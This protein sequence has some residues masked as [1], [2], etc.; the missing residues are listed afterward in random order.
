MKWLHDIHWAGLQNWYLAPIFVVL[1]ILTL[2]NYHRLVQAAWQLMHPIY[3]KTLFSNFS[4]RRHGIK[5]GLVVGS[6]VAIFIA[7]LQPQWGIVEN[8]VTQEGR[9]LLIVLDISRSM[10]AQDF[11]PNRLE[12]AKL[13]I[14]NVLNKLKFERVGLVLFS[15]EAFLQCPLTAD[16]SSFLM[17]LEQVDVET[18]SS[19]STSLDRALMQAISVF[20]KVEGRK[21]KLV[22]L[23]TDGEDFSVNLQAVR[24]QAKK[25]NI[26]LF[27]SGVASLQGAPIP[28]IDKYGKQA[29]NE[30]DAAGAIVLSKLNEKVL[31]EL[32][33]ALQGCYFKVNYDDS[34]IDGLVH[35]V[36]QFER[37]RFEDKTIALY[38]HRY[39]WLLGLA[40]LLLII[41]WI[42]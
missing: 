3:A 34:D 28:I 23:L 9:D 30:V 4:L 26:T 25:S 33:T 37:E 7:L 36:E 11:K 24:D 14:R 6:M 16:Y 17:F 27:A 40:W 18:I 20:S 22:W 21:N 1:I 29:G 38:E 31:Q 10:L 32:C 13:K 15:G 19:G 41:E 35:R 2:R 5:T 12:F 39:P 8:K 42:L